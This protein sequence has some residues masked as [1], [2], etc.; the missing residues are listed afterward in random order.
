MTRETRKIS[1]VNRGLI[2]PGCRVTHLH[3]H[4]QQTLNVIKKKFTSLWESVFLFVIKSG[5]KGNPINQSQK[6][7][8]RE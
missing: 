4:K 1:S 8:I 6:Q 5:G 2:I 7:Q 3:S